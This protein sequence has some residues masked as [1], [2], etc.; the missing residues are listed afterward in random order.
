MPEKLIT[1]IEGKK[2]IS[3]IFDYWRFYHPDTVYDFWLGGFKEGLEPQIPSSA[4]RVWAVATK[5]K[6]KH[7]Y[8][9]LPYGSIEGY[10]GRPCVEWRRIIRKLY[11]AGY[12]A[13][14]FE[15]V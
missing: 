1:E 13:V 8:A 5:R 2:H 14:Q 6:G 7:R 12:R 4:K 3:T 15:Y 9:I 11:K 10:D